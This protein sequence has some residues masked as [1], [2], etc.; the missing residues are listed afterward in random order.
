L[1][2]LAIHFVHLLVIS[3]N[4][5]FPFIQTRPSKGVETKFGGGNYLGFQ[6]SGYNVDQKNL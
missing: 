3:L 5:P 2:L 4:D 1:D 6:F